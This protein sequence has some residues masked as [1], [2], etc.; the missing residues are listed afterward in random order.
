MR[1]VESPRQ[2]CY[3]KL[4]MNAPQRSD[5]RGMY[6]ASVAFSCRR[7]ARNTYI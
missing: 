4:A 2:R 7:K 5:Y 6:S 3:A 1:S